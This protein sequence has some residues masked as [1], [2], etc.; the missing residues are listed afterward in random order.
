[1]ATC[2]LCDQVFDMKQNYMC[3]NCLEMYTMASYVR[4]H[5][6]NRKYNEISVTGHVDHGYQIREKGNVVAV[7]SDSSDGWILVSH[8]DSPVNREICEIMYGSGQNLRVRQAVTSKFFKGC[9][10]CYSDLILKD[11]VIQCDG[12]NHNFQYI[13]MSVWLMSVFKE[14]TELMFVNG[15]HFLEVC[16]FGSE[17]FLS[18][19]RVTIAISGDEAAI[20]IPKM[21]NSLYPI[22]KESIESLNIQKL[23]VVQVND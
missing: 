4:F 16:S 17:S 6:R 3:L 14:C 15:G 2:P 8:A 22:L 18:G 9:P 19:V 11:R 12:H 23:R 13:E 5:L 7:I 21:L 10:V 20:R 1:M